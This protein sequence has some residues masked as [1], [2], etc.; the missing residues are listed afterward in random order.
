MRHVQSFPIKT[1]PGPQPQT[2]VSF[3]V[4][5]DNT[6]KAEKDKAAAAND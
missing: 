6:Y 5:P 3:N 2:Q 1:A 4:L